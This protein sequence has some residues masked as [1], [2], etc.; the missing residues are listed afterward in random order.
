MKK[1]LSLFRDL[2]KPALSLRVLAGAYLI[3]LG[4][5]LITSDPEGKVSPWLIYVAPVVFW[6]IGGVFALASLYE[7][8]R[9]K[10]ETLAAAALSEAEKESPENPVVLKKYEKK[11]MDIMGIKYE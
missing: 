4:Y 7:M 1:I 9:Q 8:T 5:Q 3:Y 2:S 11:I 6:L 10:Y